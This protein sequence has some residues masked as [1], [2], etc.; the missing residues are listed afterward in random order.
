[1][2]RADLRDNVRHHSEYVQV[3]YQN[4]TRSVQRSLT[5]SGSDRD[6]TRLRDLPDKSAYKYC[7]VCSIQSMSD[8]GG[9]IVLWNVEN[10]TE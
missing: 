4:E 5:T 3:M 2:L 6:P 7:V 1:M 8:F 10:M 9:V